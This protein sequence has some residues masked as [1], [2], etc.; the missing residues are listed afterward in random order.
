MD[1]AALERRGYSIAQLRRMARRILPRLIFDFIDGGAEDEV[2]L[3]GNETTF[4][5]FAFRPRPLNGTTTRDQS[6]ELF[7]ERI[8]TPV[9]IGP[10]G[11]SGMV[12]PQ[13]EAAAA[14]AAYAAGTIWCMSH[15]STV[16]IEEMPKRS[17]AR[18][19]CSSSC[20]AIAA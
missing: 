8:A 16:T 12:W 11:L 10:T 3:R 18:Y 20:T 19:G 14:R 4:A 2:T 9:L 5:D 1:A 17:S 7:G 13:G 6:V 15:G